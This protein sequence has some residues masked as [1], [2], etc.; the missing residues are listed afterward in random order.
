MRRVL[1]VMTVV[2][3]GGWLAL[4]ACAQDAPLP[5]HPIT[6]KPEGST[7]SCGYSGSVTTGSGK[8]STSSANTCAPAGS[9]PPSY[10]QPDFAAEA[11]REAQ[12]QQAADAKKSAQQ[13]NVPQQQSAPQTSAPAANSAQQFAFPGETEVPKVNDDGTLSPAQPTAPQPRANAPAA[14]GEP[15]PATPDGMPGLHDT[16]SSGSS[17]SSSASSSSSSSDDS[18]SSAADTNP[19]GDAAPAPKRGRKKLPAVVRQ[20]PDERETED[21]QVGQFYMNDKNY[22]AAYGRAKDAI[23]IAED[24][25]EAHLLL[26]D[27]AR[28]IGKLDEAQK[29]YKRTLELDPT[30]KGK[31]SAEAALKEMGGSGSDT[32]MP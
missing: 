32:L 31:K 2:V 8:T 25:W 21:V 22:V 10:T 7:P 1:G 29:Q 19:P 28:K 12:A 9:L 5:V 24:D 15:Q 6:T 3:A 27:S 14:N 30:P 23:S 17:S 4:A 16:G 20:T 11:M 18:P 26:A 13:Q